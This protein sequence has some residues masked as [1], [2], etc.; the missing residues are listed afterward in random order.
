MDISKRTGAVRSMLAGILA[1][2]CSASAH[3]VEPFPTKPIRI[4]V[5]V[6]A[7]GWGDVTTRLVAQRMSEKLGQP[8]IVENR[9]GAGGQIGIRSVKTAPADGYTL[10][11]TGGTLAI[12]AALKLDPSRTL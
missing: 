5:P 8:L 7:G 11:A 12:Q 10:V 4:V 6:A 9:T 1:L 2:A 3:A